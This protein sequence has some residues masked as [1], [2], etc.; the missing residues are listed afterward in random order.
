MDPGVCLSPL[1]GSWKGAD[2]GAQRRRPGEGSFKDRGGE[3]K[4]KEVTKQSEFH[5]G[6]PIPPQ[7]F[8]QVYYVGCILE[9]RGTP[10]NGPMTVLFHHSDFSGLGQA[11]HQDFLWLPGWFRHKPGLSPTA[12]RVAAGLP[13]G[14]AASFTSMLAAAVCGKSNFFSSFTNG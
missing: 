12:L 5:N 14:V 7:S 1:L 4:E 10:P 6:V 3:A 11:W 9:S 8:C 13:A 2:E